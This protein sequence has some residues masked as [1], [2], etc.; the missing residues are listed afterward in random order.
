MI[1]ELDSVVLLHSIETYGLEPG[2]V[3]T[4]V[5]AYSNAQAFAVEF[6]TASGETVAVLT[7]TPA[8]IRPMTRDEI[9]HARAMPAASRAT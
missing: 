2:D 8:D 9:L 3:G 5:H 7:L 4:V 1:R 6:V